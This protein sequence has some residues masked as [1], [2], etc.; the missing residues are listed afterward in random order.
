[1]DFDKLLQD[2]ASRPGRLIVMSGPS[3]V[4][5]DTL[6]AEL[7]KVCPNIERCVTC[8]TR[9]PRPSETPGIDYNF[10]GLEEFRRM[11]DEGE[12]LEH[13]KVHLDHYGSPASSA[14][15]I[16]AMGKDA[17]LKIDVQGGLAVKK[18]VP[19][20]L[21]IFVAPPS[22]AELERRLR[23]RYTDSEAAIEKR[24]ADARR[25]IEAIPEYDYLVVNEEI[26]KAVNLL[27]C[28]IHAE[29]ARIGSGVLE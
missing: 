22:L 23:D 1:M 21:M 10:I 6:L 19:D 28:I 12:F 11:V 17:I 18:K 16:Q 7:E 5:K 8:T 4:G 13:A 2:R 20:A 26:D 29:R 24:T 25:E 14:A 15:R 9:S 3:G 27:C